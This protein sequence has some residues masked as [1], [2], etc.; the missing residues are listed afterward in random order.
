MPAALKSGTRREERETRQIKK[1]DSER[2]RRGSQGEGK[3]G[4]R[5]TRKQRQR[6]ENQ[7]VCVCVK[8]Q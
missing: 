7:K 8:K 1:K 2:G 5:I 6:E 4:G 3:Y